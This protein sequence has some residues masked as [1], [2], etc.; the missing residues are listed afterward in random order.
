MWA[1]TS[2][3]PAAFDMNDHQTHE[4]AGAS[5]LE[6][7]FFYPVKGLSELDNS[8]RMAIGFQATGNEPGV[9]PVP[10]KPV[11]EDEACNIPPKSPLE[12]RIETNGTALNWDPVSCK[13]V[14]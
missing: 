8:C 9:C 2:L 6:L 12:C 13:C 4:Q 14:P 11:S 5:L 3:D 10:G 7:E 1:G